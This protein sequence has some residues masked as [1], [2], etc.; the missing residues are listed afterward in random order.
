MESDNQS[1][2]KEWTSFKIAA[3]Y[4]VFSA[5]WILLSDQILYFWVKNPESMIK[6]EMIKG[7]FFVFISA[8]IIF[9]ILRREIAKYLHTEKALL[10]SEKK[11]KAILNHQ[12]QLTGLLDTHGKLI[13]ANQTVYSFAG[14]DSSELI[15]KY[16][17]QLPHWSHSKEEQLKVQTAV[18]EVMKGNPVNFESTHVDAE[19][20]LSYIAFSLTPVYNDDGEMIYIV[21]EGKDIT[22][23]NEWE[24]KLI[25]SERNYREIYNSSSDAI[26]IHDAKT[27]K[28]V[29]VNETMLKMYGYS[30]EEALE[31]DMSDVSSGVTPFTEKEA[32]KKIKHAVDKGPQLFEWMA[33]T[34]TN[35]CFWVEVALQKTQISGKGR[36]LAVVRDIRKRKKLDQ[37]LN[38]I[39][40]S[41]EYSAY[42]FH[43]IKKD[44]HF[45]YNNKA[46]CDSLGYTR[47]ELSS[48]RVSDINPDFTSERWPN[49]WEELKIEKSVTFD[50]RHRHKNGEIFPVEINA[51][52]MEFDDQEHV[53]VYIKNISDKIQFEKKQKNL[54]KQLQQAQKMEALGTLAGGVAHDF[55]NI[56]SAIMGYSELALLE[57]T[58]AKKSQAYVKK[59]MTAGHRATKLVEQI[60]AFSRHNDQNLK[61]QILGPIIKEVL[62]LLRS[63]I[64]S[65]IE[66]KSYIDPNCGLVLS[67]PTQIQQIV[68]N[69]STNAYHAMRNTGGRMTIN[70]RPTDR[71]NDDNLFGN[72]FLEPGPYLKLE[73]SDTGHGMSEDHM[74][75]IFNPYFTTKKKG[76][77]TGLGLSIVHGIVKSLNGDIDLKSKVGEG[78]SVFVYLPVIE[79]EEPQKMELESQDPLP[80]GNERILFVDDEKYVVD[81]SEIMLASMGYSVVG[82]TD[83]EAALE[84]FKNDPDDFDLVVTDLT[85]PY[86]TGKQLT[87]LIHDVR[88]D[89]PVILCTGYGDPLPQKEAEALGIKG[90]LIKPIL[91]KDLAEMIRQVLDN[92]RNHD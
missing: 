84:A 32:S 42:P 46:A 49:H 89:L 79:E 65:T 69:L 16:I 13:M 1:S 8:M 10:N 66:I 29:D 68:M 73:I 88:P 62:Q 52:Y 36:V 74:D 21:P 20:E 40:R 85:M 24:K 30:Y 26:F 83:S 5:L 87:R 64:P 33:K 43:W 59:V 81:F 39:K 91:K 12:F 90:Y 58:D 28:I 80:Q 48:M 2:V 6:I 35:T 75:K 67:D 25:E 78:T 54:E 77:G 44:G 57:I 3:I 92:G 61:P 47:E 27:G 72:I 55:N 31:L 7:W 51:N 17:W 76:E 71:T 4:A 11:F 19:G 45:F 23:R 86:L 14:V 22:A 34:K 9:L 38:L 82:F 60:L 56:L 63:S 41:I 37:E 53:F 70:L 50:T 18:Q 15:G